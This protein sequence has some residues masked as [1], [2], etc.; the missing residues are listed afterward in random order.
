MQHK[1]VGGS[2]FG[3]RQQRSSRLAPRQFRRTQSEGPALQQQRGPAR[4]SGS[5]GPDPFQCPPS[6]CEARSSVPRWARLNSGCDARRSADHNHPP[7]PGG[8]LITCGPPATVLS[9]SC[10]SGIIACLATAGGVTPIVAAE[11]TA[12]G[13]NVLFGMW[14]PI[15][16]LG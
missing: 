11:S 6:C 9:S 4:Q 16:Y 14:I 15:K 13:T 7:G 8:R 12:F 3:Q 10:E 1:V 5:V 2:V